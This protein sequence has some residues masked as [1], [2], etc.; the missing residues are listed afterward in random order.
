MCDSW[1][2]KGRGVTFHDH[3]VLFCHSRE[4]KSLF[5]F[6]HEVGIN[7]HCWSIKARLWLP[8]TLMQF[9]GIFGI[10]SDQLRHSEMQIGAIDVLVVGATESSCHNGCQSFTKG[11]VVCV[12]AYKKVELASHSG[13]L[14]DQEQNSIELSRKR[15]VTSDFQVPNF[16]IHHCQG[17][18][19]AV[20]HQ[21][22]GNDDSPLQMESSEKATKLWQHLGIFAIWPDF[23]GDCRLK[24]HWIQLQSKH[25]WYF[26]LLWAAD[27]LAGNWVEENG[28]VHQTNY[29]TTPDSDRHLFWSDQQSSSYAN[30]PSSLS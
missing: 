8:R 21:Q 29:H 22:R 2:S 4:L 3:H 24:W 27:K 14:N 23:N 9:N 6:T 12:W 16:C 10:L 13:W 5:R 7:E 19:I 25:G 26:W 18:L 20:W 17:T 11:L 1:L 28:G 30:S 15:R